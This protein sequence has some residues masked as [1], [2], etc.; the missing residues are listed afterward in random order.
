MLANR[1]PTKKS[2]QIQNC[3]RK[4]NNKSVETRHVEIINT[5]SV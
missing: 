1:M 2:F 4:N 5:G 3:R